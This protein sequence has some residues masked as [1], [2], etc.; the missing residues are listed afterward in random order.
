MQDTPKSGVAGQATTALC[1]WKDRDDENV[2]QKVQGE[3]RTVECAE[4]KGAGV[5]V[6]AHCTRDVPGCVCLGGA[7]C[8]LDALTHQLVVGGGVVAHANSTHKRTKNQKRKAKA[9]PLVFND[10]GTENKK[11]GVEMESAVLWDEI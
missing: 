10:E 3:K 8:Q 1:G 9:P 7:S 4:K 11:R 6:E 2:V 5:G